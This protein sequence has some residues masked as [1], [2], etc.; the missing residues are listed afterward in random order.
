MKPRLY[1]L[2]RPALVVAALAL[3]HAGLC[4]ADDDKP[5][6]EPVLPKK[7]E[8]SDKAKPADK[9]KDTD[10]DKAV[11]RVA[12]IKLSGSL[13]EAPAG[14]SLFGASAETLAVKLDRINKAAKDDRVQLL[15]LDIGSVTVGFGK[16]HE[17]QVALANFRAAGKKVV[18]FAEELDTKGYLVALSCDEIILPES[19][20]INVAGLRAEVS[21]Y[22][23]ALETLKLKADVLKVGDY[24]SA[25]EPYLADKMSA[26]NREQLEALVGDNYDNEVVAAMVKG[27]PG[28]KWTADAAKAVIDQ[29]PF[30][31][32]RALKLGLI[33]RNAYEDELDGIYKKMLSTDKVRVVE[34]YGRAKADAPDFS[35][36][37]KLLEALSGPK[38]VAE[39]K[40]PKVAVIYAV[41]A[42]SSGK[43]GGSLFGGGSG[44]GSETIVE[45]V[46]AAEKDDTVKAIV[47]RV[48]SPGGSALASDVMYRA[49][50]IAKKPVVVSMGDVAASG[51]Y[52]I[53]AAGK[54]IFAEPG[55]VTG[56]IG[57]FGLKFVTGGLEEWAGVR[58]EVISRGKNSGVNSTTFAWSDSERQV[59]G[60]GVMAI[61][62]QFLDR[63]LEGRKTAGKAMTREELKKLAGGRVWTG[64][65]A[66]A[67]GLVDELGTLDDAV[68]YAQKLG[69]LDTEKP[70]ER[71]NL[72]KPASFFDKLSDGNGLDLPFGSLEAL[73]A[74]PGGRKAAEM[75]S[76]LFATQGQPMKMLLPYH[77][78]WK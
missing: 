71:L 44:V 70:A 54:R 26:A 62:E 17:L 3:G 40:A 33:S 22:K 49:L 60:E 7:A 76:P 30:T 58:T 37:F 46:R 4:L 72:P 6:Q 36:P 20:G 21:F 8:K 73:N 23:T 31:A 24:K 59:L 47:L 57:V 43:G 78:E 10:A 75:L 14:E 65:Q 66:L 1:T 41:G 18:A 56:S 5:K 69:G 77:L 74:L 35:N 9:D 63:S 52:Y 15:A 28:Q 67:N 42:I 64:R 12:K 38:K 19:G 45:A 61:Y 55:T 39:S 48:D 29:G 13:G 51:G 53:A 25:V 11:P 27:R 50:K 2:A 16:I 34:N 32:V 68:K